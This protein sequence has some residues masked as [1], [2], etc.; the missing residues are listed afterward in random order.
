MGDKGSGGR[1]ADS[2]DQTIYDQFYE[3][4]LSGGSYSWEGDPGRETAAMMGYQ[5]GQAAKPVEMPSFEMPSIDT[6]AYDKQME[7]YE[8]AQA[9]AERN[10]GIAERDAMYSGYLD[11]ANTA[12]DYVT[13]EI[14]SEQANARL[15]GIDY[16]MNDELKNQR[17]SDYF[18][19]VWGEG[20][21]TQLEGLFDK[22]GTPTGFNGFQVARGD[23][24]K[25]A[26]QEGTEE[27]VAIS[28]GQKPILAAGDE[29]EV[30]GA[31]NN[32]LGG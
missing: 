23:A 14:A 1:E 11:A 16:Q 20:D 18:A 6:S 2:L 8:A 30:L 32:V 21:Q 31:T 25:Y 27:Q 26:T 12:A 9:E 4:G 28:Q 24:S 19:S 17:V 15:L 22:W 29:E 3:A 10:A 7:D 13:S 5:A